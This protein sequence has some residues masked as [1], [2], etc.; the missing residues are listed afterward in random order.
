MI[1]E[2]KNLTPIKNGG[3]KEVYRGTHD[4]HGDI[5]FKKIFP[6]SDSLER[7]KREIRAVSIFDKSPNIPKIIANN[8]EEKNP[9]FIW[10]IEEYISG[11]NLRD[12]I[13]GGRKFTIG[14][15]VRFLDT[16]L[17][18]S[19][20]SENNQLVHRDIKPENI[21]IDDNDDFWL[22][23]FGIARHLDMESITKSDDPFGL[24]TVGYASSE[25]FRNYKKDIDI[26]AD[27]F[28][29]GVVCYEL[30][31]GQ[32]FYML[33]VDNDIFKVLRKLENSSLPP[34]RIQGDGQFQLSTF[35][36]LLGD[37]RRNRRPNTAKE[38]KIIFDTLKETLTLS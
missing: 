15:I 13:N 14:D 10:I 38:A 32:N 27:L 33:D 31:R 17:E 28:S 25:Q 18:I 20:H 26:R 3:Q 30:L 16:M 34:L 12:A 24:F 8:C 37:H 1:E 35:I 11:Q 2:L 5:V 36:S 7:T 19:V 21:I 6:H 23:D 29:I 9:E 22:L 4:I